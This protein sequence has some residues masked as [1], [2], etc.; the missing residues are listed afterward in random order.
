[1]NNQFVIGETLYHKEREQYCLYLGT[2]GCRN[3]KCI[4]QLENGEFK[5]VDIEQLETT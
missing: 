2:K 1:M 5:Q 3:G 4:V